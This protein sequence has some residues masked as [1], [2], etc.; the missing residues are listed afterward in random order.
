MIRAVAR[1]SATSLIIAFAAS[2]LLFACSPA[3]I[4]TAR[5]VERPVPLAERLSDRHDCWSGNAPADMAGEIPGHVVVTYEGRTVY[6]AALVGPALEQLFDGTD[7][8]LT[9]HAF[10]R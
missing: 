1:L 3:P 2:A 10:C 5:P 7:H 9:V 6:S 8:G 4:T